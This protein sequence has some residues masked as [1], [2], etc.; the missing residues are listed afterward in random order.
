MPTDM[1]PGADTP[2]IDELSSAEAT[3]AELQQVVHH[4][5]SDDLAKQTAC[6]EFDI[7]GLTDHLM[8]SISSLGEMA[9]AEL[10]PRTNTDSVERQI[11]LAARPALDAWRNRG[12]DGTVQFR[13]NEAPANVMAG[14]LSIEFL[15]HAWD[16][17]QA[18]DQSVDPS[19]ELA[20]FVFG[21]ARKIITPEGR[22]NVGFDDP[23]DVPEDAAMFDRLLAYTGRRP[24]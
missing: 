9:G 11:I 21:L 23:I 7:A 4:I 17:A 12:L 1:P 13:S 20:E 8:N 24:N 15:I 5:S 10:P 14:V 18:I 3:L 22:S 19:D 6:R 16:Y 2:P